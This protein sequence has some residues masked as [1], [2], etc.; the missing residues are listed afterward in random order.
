MI[1][2]TEPEE[3]DPHCSKAR[4]CWAHAACALCVRP[5]VCAVDTL[6]D[7]LCALLIHCV[8]DLLCAYCW[9]TVRQAYCACTMCILYIHAYCVN[10]VAALWIRPTVCVPLAHCVRPTVCVLLAHCV[11]GLLCVLCVCLQMPAHMD[12]LGA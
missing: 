1:S 11:S 7:L 12:C 9:H 5:T 4:A 3:T 6:S 8:S 2:T 10:T